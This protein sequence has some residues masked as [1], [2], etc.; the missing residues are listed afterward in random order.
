[1]RRTIILAGLL[2]T[3]TTPATAMGLE[4]L[5]K[6]VIGGQ[7][8]LKK[9]NE[10]CP[11]SS[12]SLTRADQ[13]AL[14]FARSAAEQALPISQLTAISDASSAEAA[15]EAQKPAFCTETKRKKSGLMTKIKKAGRQLAQARLG[16]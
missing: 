6:V 4:D 3:V 9:A 16:L 8:V 11:R 13:L 1:M 7:S 2:G 12:F 5:A 14:T 10:D 15:V